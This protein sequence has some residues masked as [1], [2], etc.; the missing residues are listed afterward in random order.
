[1]AN[2]VVLEK[3]LAPTN[4]SEVVA[5]AADLSAQWNTI[6]TAEN[7]VF[8]ENLAYSPLTQNS[9]S[10]ATTAITAAGLAPP[11]DTGLFSDHWAPAS[12]NVLATPMT[13]ASIDQTD[14]QQAADELSAAEQYTGYEGGGAYAGGD[15]GGGNYGGGGYYGGGYYGGGYYGYGSN[16]RAVSKKT[17][18]A[19]SE[20]G[21]IGRFDAH[22]EAL[23]AGAANSGARQGFDLASATQAF[24]AASASNGVLHAAAYDGW[25]ASGAAATDMGQLIQA[26]ASFDVDGGAA[27][28]AVAFHPE[29]AVQHLAAAAAHHA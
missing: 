6:V 21:A 20:I 22:H 23:A 28:T 18:G 12:G 17:V 19:N 11:A 10:V 2:T 5:S 1:M 25:H 24:G 13:S 26:M 8:S 14:A 9:N 16:D 3:L 7:E 27:D 29:M 4:P 15:W